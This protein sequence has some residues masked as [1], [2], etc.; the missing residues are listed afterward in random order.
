MWKDG[1][2]LKLRSRQKSGWVLND[3]KPSHSWS[4]SACAT[5]SRIAMLIVLVTHLRHFCP[6]YPFTPQ[7]L[8]SWVHTR[9]HTTAVTSTSPPTAPPVEPQTQ[10]HLRAVLKKQQ[11]SRSPSSSPIADSLSSSTA[12]VSS[13]ISRP[14]PPSLSAPSPHPVVLCP[15]PPPQ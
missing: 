4:N 6:T 11:R 2:F 10:P 5:A 12:S 14:A 13:S 7:P 15:P 3:T 8:L 9:S 1:I